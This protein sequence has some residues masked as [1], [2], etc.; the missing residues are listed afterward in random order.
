MQ[1]GL[2]PR[3]LDAHLGVETICHLFQRRSP[4]VTYSTR[5]K[6]L[7]R[8]LALALSL[9]VC[10]RD[11]KTL[12]SKARRSRHHASRNSRAA[13]RESCDERRSLLSADASCRRARQ[14]PAQSP[15]L[16]ARRTMRFLSS[17]THTPNTTPSLSSSSSSSSSESAAATARGAA[18]ELS[19]K[20]LVVFFPSSSVHAARVRGAR[21]RRPR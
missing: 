21:A 10:A 12:L 4:P 16:G 2:L 11:E 1:A 7:S 18:G 5:A 20:Y 14:D 15:R 6:P 8:S 3:P 13:P 9:S 17:N 19:K